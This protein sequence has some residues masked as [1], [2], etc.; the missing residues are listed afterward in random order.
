MPSDTRPDYTFR[1]PTL[2]LWQSAAA[3]TAWTQSKGEEAF[4]IQA[5]FMTPVYAVA[6]AAKGTAEVPTAAPESAALVADCSKLASQFLWAEI[7]GN[8]QLAAQCAAELR[9]S[10][11]DV[12]GWSTCLTNYLKFKA[13]GGS[14]PYLE[15]K[16]QVQS[17]DSN[18]RIALVGDWGTG[19]GPA[20][21]LL[22]QVKAQHPDLLIHLGDIYYSC[23][24]Q[25]AAKNFLEI[26]R[27]TFEPGFPLFTLC[28]N[29]DMY[30][31][32]NGYYWLLKQIHQQASY[33]IL[34][35]KDWQ[36]LAMDT[37]HN[38]RNPITVA[39]NMT[40]LN[41]NE[42]AWL[43]NKIKTGPSRKT[44]L[45][46]H[47]Q[48]FSAFGA[49]GQVD[50]QAY[51][52]NPNLYKNFRDVLDQVEW[53]FWGHEHNLAAYEPYMG[54]KR[55]RCIGCSAVPVFKNQQSYTLDRSLVTLEHGRFPE[56]VTAA[57]LGN[58]GTDYNHAFAIL[59]LTA[60]NASAEY[61]QVPIN[62]SASP[63]WSEP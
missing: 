21:N 17:I 13:E 35:N 29:H 52:Y 16:D 15:N 12:A 53:W 50:G 58:N 41:P 30:S 49:V 7:K 46:S 43:L 23:T 44:I 39:S 20:V 22:T 32:G 33:F 2:S 40:S 62:Q 1:D 31:G 51:A 63:L 18:V 37:G 9:K 47:H 27:A 55:G 54:L 3:V 56:W 26:C 60:G 42:V 61:F 25:E 59:T 19:E 28:G 34:T 11:C 57:Q 8:R 48:L 45:L 6:A 24:Q 38:D 10:V 5:N 36:L 4:A 14:F